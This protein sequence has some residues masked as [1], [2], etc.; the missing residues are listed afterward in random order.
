MAKAISFTFETKGAPGYETLVV[1]TDSEKDAWAKA[2]AFLSGEK[3]ESIVLRK[4]F[5]TGYKLLN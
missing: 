4:I 2:Y 1:T 3:I 5:P